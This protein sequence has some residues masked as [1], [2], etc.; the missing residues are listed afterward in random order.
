[1]EDLLEEENTLFAELEHQLED[2]GAQAKADKHMPSVHKFDQ[3]HAK[4]M[5]ALLEEHKVHLARLEESF[6]LDRKRKMAELARRKKERREKKMQQ[7]AAEENP[8]VKQ[9]LVKELK[10]D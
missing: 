3:E 4:S 7:I 10:E 6:Q 9:M 8:E 2:F 5:G 1:M